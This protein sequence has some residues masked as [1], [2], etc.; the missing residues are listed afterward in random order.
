MT[1]CPCCHDVLDGGGSVERVNLVVIKSC[2]SP[3]LSTAF[4]SLYRMWEGKHNTARMN[5][6]HCCHFLCQGNAESIRF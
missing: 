3:A 4:V 5:G 6:E 2:H 1:P